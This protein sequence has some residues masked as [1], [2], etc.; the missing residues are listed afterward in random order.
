VITVREFLFAVPPKDHAETLPEKRQRWFENAMAIMLAIAAISATWSSFQSSQWSGKASGLVSQ[1]S[2][3]RADSNRYASKAVEETSI[4]ASLWIEWQKAV[5]R[6]EDIL[7]T[8]LAGRFS[9]A[10]DKAQ[11][12]WLAKTPVDANGIPASLPKGTPLTLDEYVPPGQAKAETLSAQAESQLAEASKFS[13]VSGRYIML[14]VLFALVL[15]FGNVATKFSGPKIQLALGAVSM[16][17][18]ASS[19]LR[20]LLL[21]I[22]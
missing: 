15:F 17:L 16:T 3:A 5:L 19:V 21:P 13:S 8:F 20:M 12:V 18:L 10:L 7:A 11:D 22:L 14:T 2:I 4:D 6:G 9:P 1:S